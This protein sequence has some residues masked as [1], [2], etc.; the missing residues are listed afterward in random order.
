MS[1]LHLL[2]AYLHGKYVE[3]I[4]L[5]IVKR[6]ENCQIFIQIQQNFKKKNK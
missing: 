1:S 4:N 3:K 2:Y 6:Q 5:K